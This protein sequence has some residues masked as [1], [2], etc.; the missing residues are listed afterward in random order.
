MRVLASD[1]DD[2]ILY[3]NDKGAT[4]TGPRPFA[5]YPPLFNTVRVIKTESVTI[6]DQKSIASTGHRV[7]C[8]WKS[9]QGVN[10]KST[11]SSTSEGILKVE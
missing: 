3:S 6:V 4:T 2:A 11:K 1:F 5:T 10:N 8:L 7:L 9:T